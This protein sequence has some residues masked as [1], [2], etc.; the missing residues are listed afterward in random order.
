MHAN[1]AP[2]VEL[3]VAAFPEGEAYAEEV[4]AIRRY[5]K[6]YQLVELPVLA[7]RS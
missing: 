2:G 3:L 6:A 1:N 5:G 4:T 7:E